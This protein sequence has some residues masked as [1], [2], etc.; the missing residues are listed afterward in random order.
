MLKKYKVPGFALG[1]A[2]DGELCYGKEFE[3]RDVETKL[4]LSP[5]TVFG[6]GSITKAFTSVAILQLQEKG[7]LS[8][9]E[10]V[11]NYL[12]EFKT[13]NEA[14]TKQITIH[15]ILT[16]S[17]GLLPLATLLG[18]MKESIEK[19]PK[20]E[21]DQQQESPLDAMIQAIDTHS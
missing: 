17:S 16:H 10:C 11:T 1:L 14:Q 12:P 8:V 7:K 21:E 2:K 18:A 13:A 4:P 5:D 19:E 15:H 9:N 6:V 20:L 3:F